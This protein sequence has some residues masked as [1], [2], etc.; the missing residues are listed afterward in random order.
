MAIPDRSSDIWRA[1]VLTPDDGYPTPT[2]HAQEQTEQE[3]VD[4]GQ[5]LSDRTTLKR[6]T[7]VQF[8]ARNLLQGFPSRYQAYDCSQAWLIYWTLQAFALL[9]V[10]MDPNNRQKYVASLKSEAI[11]R[12]FPRI[13]DKVLQWQ[14][15]NGGFGGGPGQYAHLLGTYA[16]V[17]SLAIAGKPGPGGGWDQIDR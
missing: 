17:C 16:A 1:L 15:P 6:D 2:S 12:A 9:Q 7:H 8:L 3:L 14:H 10:G 5:G 11:H 4:A 13:V